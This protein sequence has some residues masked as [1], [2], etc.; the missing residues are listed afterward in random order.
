M[1]C[2]KCK[3]QVDKNGN[4]CETYKEHIVKIRQWGLSKGRVFN[5]VAEK[6]GYYERR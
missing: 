3:N 1:S 5:M 4:Q 2:L 6:C